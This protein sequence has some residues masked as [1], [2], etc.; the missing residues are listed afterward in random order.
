MASI[1]PGKLQSAMLGLIP[2]GVI[3]DPFGSC[4]TDLVHD[5]GKL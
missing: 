4:F 5:L 2:I 1:L 3:A